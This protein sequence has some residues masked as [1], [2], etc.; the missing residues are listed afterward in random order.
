M[1]EKIKN[2]FDVREGIRSDCLRATYGFLQIFSIVLAYPIYN[3]LEKREYFW[4]FS[5]DIFRFLGSRASV[6]L[7]MLVIL[8]IGGWVIYPIF[9]L[10]D[11]KNRQKRKKR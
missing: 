3:A 11:K 5:M 4:I 1:R 8:G 2:F 7:I 10:L 9:V 6:G